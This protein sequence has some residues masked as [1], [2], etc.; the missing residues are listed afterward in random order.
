MLKEYYLMVS[1]GFF[2]NQ[3]KAWSMPAVHMLNVDPLI[4][5]T[6]YNEI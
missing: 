6:E 2:H 3:L 5:C 1:L 4:K